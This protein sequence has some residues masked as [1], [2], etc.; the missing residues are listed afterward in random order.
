MANL[1]AGSGTLKS[2]T[3]LLSL[4]GGEARKL[5]AGHVDPLTLLEAEP[6]AGTV[7]EC[8][9]VA[10]KRL[11]ARCGALEELSVLVGQSGGKLSGLAALEPG[12]DRVLEGEFD[13][14]KREVPCDECQL[15]VQRAGFQDNYKSGSRPKRFPPSLLRCRGRG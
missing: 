8:R 4:D 14:I 1:S 6:A 7:E 13:Q 12:D 2:G 3:R 11:V 9:A 5:A 15:R 10:V